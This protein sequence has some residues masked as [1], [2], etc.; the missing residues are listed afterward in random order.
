MAQT[1]GNA[2]PEA[3]SDE[4]PGSMAPQVFDGRGYVWIPRGECH[5][6]STH[7]LILLC[8]SCLRWSN[9]TET[10]HPATAEA[11]W[12]REKCRM[13]G[14]TVGGV[15]GTLLRPQSEAPSA[16]MPTSQ[17][18]LRCASS[19]RAQPQECHL[20][21]HVC[22]CRPARHKGT[23]PLTVVFAC[24]GYQA[25]NAVTGLPL[26]MCAEELWLAESQGQCCC[27]P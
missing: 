16:V 14:A 19:A 15:A 12:M 24:A 10:C 23:S 2:A 27:F 20:G 8:A 7:L 18:A 9:S 22:C 4:Q 11:R 5:V 25:Q 21:Q 3:A 13:V 1:E 6:P 17:P 26:Q